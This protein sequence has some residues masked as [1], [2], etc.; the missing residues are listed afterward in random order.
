MP[1]TSRNTLWTKQ[2]KAYGINIGMIANDIKL[3]LWQILWNLCCIGSSLPLEQPDGIIIWEK[4]QRNVMWKT[5]G[6]KAIQML[7]SNCLDYSHRYRRTFL[8]LRSRQSSWRYQIAQSTLVGKCLYIFL[9]S[10]RNISHHK[11]LLV[12]LCCLVTHGNIRS[13]HQVLPKIAF[14]RHKIV[15]PLGS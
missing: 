9:S 13:S 1:S 14:P 3:L 4:R 6:V 11:M 10:T 5:Y 8:S 12:R 7:P 15:S 2:T